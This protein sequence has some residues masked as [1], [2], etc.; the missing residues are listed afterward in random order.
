MLSTYAGLLPHSDA[1]AAERVA[2]VVTRRTLAC[3]QIE[4]G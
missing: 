3:Q 4:A 1:E 2:A